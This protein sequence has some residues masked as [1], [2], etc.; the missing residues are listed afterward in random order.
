MQMINMFSKERLLIN[1]DAFDDENR[2]V[3]GVTYNWHADE[4]LQVI[5]TD[6]QVEVRCRDAA[7]GTFT[8]ECAASVMGSEVAVDHIVIN[9]IPRKVRLAFD[10][11]VEPLPASIPP[12]LA[13]Q[14]GSVDTFAPGLCN[15]N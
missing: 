1:I 11:R 5:V 8:L 2:K 6:D 3:R 12:T 15:G 10:L 14:A 7:T 13:V 4:Q 9:S